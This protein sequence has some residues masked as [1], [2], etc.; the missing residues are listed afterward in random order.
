[1]LGFLLS[2][3]IGKVLA[4]AGTTKARAEEIAE[5]TATR[6][7]EFGSWKDAFMAKLAGELDPSLNA[8]TIGGLVSGAV[9]ELKSKHPGF[10]RHTFGGG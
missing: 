9:D 8:E 7:P 2:E 6:H 3:A 5:D 10:N 1:M 4:A